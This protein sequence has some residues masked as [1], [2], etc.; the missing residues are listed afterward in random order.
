MWPSVQ[1]AFVPIS[2]KLEGYLPWMY[3]DILG[4]VTT[5]MGNKVD[6]VSQALSLP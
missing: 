3:L 2:S 6:P 4:W 5:G 1:A